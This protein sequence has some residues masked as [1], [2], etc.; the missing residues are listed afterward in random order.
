MIPVRVACRTD[1]AD[2]IIGLDLASLDDKPLP[3][4][5]AG[6]HIDLVLGNGLTRQYS[7]CGSPDEAGHYKIA[8]L[9][10]T[11]SRGG[12][13]FVHDTLVPGAVVDISQ[14]RNLFVLK[15]DADTYVLVAGGIGIT[16]I[17]AMAYRLSGL[18]KAFVLHYCAREPARAAF[19][20]ELKTSGLA[21]NVRLHFD[22][23]PDSRLDLDEA[24]EKPCTSRQ[25]YVCGPTGFMDHVLEAARQR[26]WAEA[27]VHREYF[28]APVGQA[29]DNRSFEMI[30]GSTGQSLCVGPDQ[31][32]AQV[33][34]AAGVFVPLSCEQGICGTCLTPV[35]AG[36]PDHRDLF[37]TDEEK[38]SNLQFTP[39]CSRS[40]TA[41][42]TLDL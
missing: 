32:A 30:I 26:G 2:G 19:L 9:R 10:E 31:T 12:S 34:E 7:L 38:A 40:L 20:E 8:V 16:P 6:S 17:L 24:L 22:S 36:T 21:P 13:Q 42:L 23:D 3:P 41:T 11:S 15:E 28:T 18:G 27:Q 14:P 37:Q 4:F 35:L 33:L 29:D 25:L 1:A 39:C 5:T